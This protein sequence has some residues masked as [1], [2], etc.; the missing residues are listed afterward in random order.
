MRLISLQPAINGTAFTRGGFCGK[1]QKTLKWLLTKLSRT[2]NL[3]AW[4][5]A[6]GFEVLMM[7]YCEWGNSSIMEKCKCSCHGCV[8]PSAAGKNLSSLAE[9][10]SITVSRSS[11]KLCEARRCVLDNAR[12][13]WRDV[14]KQISSINKRHQRP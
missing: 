2:T 10:K 9:H 5:M 13:Y 12:M 4:Q 8:R 6:A 7:F 1:P 11:I 3:M 14:M